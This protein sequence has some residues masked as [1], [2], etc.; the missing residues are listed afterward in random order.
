MK[1]LRYNGQ[2]LF[3]LVKNMGLRYIL[4][5]I[6]YEIQRLTGVLQLRFP[7]KSAAR[8]F[9][10]MTDWRNL[11]VR[12]FSHD[13][14]LSIEKDVDLNALKHL[15]DEMRQNRFLFFSSEW[16]A[17]KDWHTNPRNGFTYDRA[18]HWTEIP[19]FLKEAGDI[20]YVWEKSRF[21]F[22][23]DLIRYDLH[24]EEDQSQ[25]VFS[26]ILDWINENPVNCGPNWKCGQEI[27]LRV[28]NWVFA[29]HYYRVSDNLTQEIFDQII[30]S[31]YDQMV[32][33]AENIS[34]S[35]TVVRNN[36]ALTE[37]LALYIIGLLFPFFP[38]SRHWR[39]KGKEWFET[40]IEYQIDEEGTFLQFSMNYHRIVVQLLAWAFKLA[41]L[42]GEH[43]G[44]NVYDRARKSVKFLH[45]CQDDKSGWLP[46]YG[47]NDGALFFPLTSC[48][49]RDFRPQLTALSRLLEM[50]L[51]YGNGP[52]NEE[53]AWLGIEKKPKMV[54]VRETKWAFPKGGYYLLRDEYSTTFLRCGAYQ[55]RPF[56]ADNLHLDIWVNGKNILRDAGTYSY[57]TDGQCAEYFSGTI[58][59]NTAMPGN[60]DQMSKQSRFIWFHWVRKARGVIREEHGFQIIEAEFEGFEHIG[61]GIIHKR[62]VM[63]KIGSLHW[64]IEDWLENVPAQLPMN[65]IWHPCEDFSAYYEMKSWD[66]NGSE[67]FK[68]I[69]N[70][71]YAEVYGQK[72][73]CRQWIFSTPRKYIKTILRAIN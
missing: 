69:S 52:W 5:R 55:N 21:T 54:L 31:I 58:A 63:K 13:R 12:F 23:Y 7:T 38:E 47:H 2:L 33:V 25:L 16:F 41:E 10:S 57:Y 68:T 61:R 49:F 15:M 29:L 32:H 9:I 3:H 51:G 17:V 22:L 48:H 20:K 65:Q 40:E 71:W 30:G 27:S 73:G 56:Q 62:K 8:Y 67:I 34:F 53:S 50:G 11:P 4:F 70:G 35:R 45:A 59:H 18:Q 46:N 26:L 42:N 66:E 1:K 6:W 36:H 19:D 14:N 64:Q 72:A 44:E 37:T 39:K 60:Y 28:L 43:W 24:F